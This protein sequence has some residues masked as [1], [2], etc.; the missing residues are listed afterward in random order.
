MF[1][2]GGRKMAAAAVVKYTT[3]DSFVLDVEETVTCFC[4]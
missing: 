2:R 1:G 4:R 3:M